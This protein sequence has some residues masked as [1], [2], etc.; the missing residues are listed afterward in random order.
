M[1]TAA[2]LMSGHVLAQESPKVDQNQGAIGESPAGG[3]DLADIIPLATKLSGRLSAL[4]NSIKSGPDILA[5]EK[6]YDDRIKSNLDAAH[7]LEQ[8]KNSKDYKYNRLLALK[9]VLEKENKALNKINIPISQAIR[10]LASERKEWLAEKL[11]WEEWQFL[12]LKEGA[13]DQLR[14]TLKKTVD[15][16]DTALD[17]IVPQLKSMLSVQEKS[18]YL[19]AKINALALELDGLVRDERRRVFADES[20]PMFSSRYFS[21]F[22]K[23][24]WYTVQKDFVEISWP[25]SQGFARYGWI[26]LLQAFLILFVIITVYRKRQVLNESSRWQFLAERPFSAGVFLG[27][28]TAV[29]IYEYEGASAIWKMVNTCVT[30]V[31]FARLI[32]G[33]IKTPWKK[34]FVNGLI[35]VFIFTRLMEVLS[36]P[37]PIFRLYTALT[38]LVGVIFCLRWSGKSSMQGSSNLYTWL[39]RLGS[40]FLAV[41][42]ISELWGKRVMAS[43]LFISSIRSIS[44]VIVFMFLMYMFHGGLEWLFRTSLFRR[45]EVV[46]SDTD[47]IIRRIS[48]FIDLAISGLVLLPAI[49]MIWGVYGS[50]K[51]ATKGLLAIGFTLG[52]QRISVGLV[53]ASFGIIYGSFLISWFL[54]K[55]LMNEALVK[56]RMERGV[57][58]SIGKLIHY[59]IICVGFF[60]ALSTLGFEIS[61]L[62]IMVS[63]LGVGIG[64]GLQGVVNNFVSGLILLFE[65]PIR[66][67][68]SVEIDGKFTEIKRIGLR[69]TTVQ[70][71]EQADLIIPNADLVTNQVTNWTLSNRQARLTIPVGVA[72]GSDVPLVMETLIECGRKQ[73]LVVGFRQPQVLFVSFGESTLDFEL[74]VWVKDVEYR[75]KASSDLHQEID[76]KFREMNIEIAFPQSDLHVRSLDESVVLRP[77]ET[78]RNLKST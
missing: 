57:R 66:V 42:M 47:V 28:L 16:I 69:A 7:Q 71:V 40:L 37:L 49:L 12:L 8:L 25:D 30:G 5:V 18:G 72:Y 38:A 33:L 22:S 67:G 60:V 76:R 62:T 34:Q 9:E 17:L 41:I 68:D 35:I 20:S 50:L 6:K 11:R 24:L 54:Q 36:F 65:R 45:K 75:L 1:L 74:R 70:T 26:V 19:Q 15:T 55:L 43:Y 31:S 48:L 23:S 77:S 39:F 61:K 64:F 13:F 44:A 10:Q 32:G 14:S 58:H 59:V 4:Q 29:L 3:P 21:Q 46:H 56:R 73:E 27:T 63:A 78:E 51:E 2:I 53:I 52:S